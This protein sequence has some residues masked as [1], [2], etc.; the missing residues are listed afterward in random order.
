[1]KK[2]D[3]SPPIKAPT[4]A[5]S[6][7]PAKVLLTVGPEVFLARQ[8][9]AG[10]VKS[11]RATAPQIQV[12]ELA[13]K[14]PN[15]PM[16]V[17]EA[18]SPSLFASQSLVLITD[19][20]GKSHHGSDN[21]ASEAIDDASDVLV[22][23]IKG[24]PPEI[25]LGLDLAT[26]R[27]RKQLIEAAQLA[28]CQEVEC[29]KPSPRSIDTFIAKEFSK[30]RR[31]AAPEAI[32][33]L[34]QS[35][36]DDLPLLANAIEQICSDIT[37]ELISL[38]SV[39]IYHSGIAELPWYKVSEAVWSGSAVNVMNMVRE[40]FARDTTAALPMIAALAS[41]IRLM[42]RVAGL[43]RGM[44]EA[45]A[46]KQLGAH[47]YRV[48]VARQQL[49]RWG[50]TVLANAI[51]SLAELDS[52]VKGGLAGTGLDANARQHLVESAFVRIAAGRG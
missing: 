12:I 5:K 46:G 6:T 26:S 39:Q 31:Q 48:K 9:V 40:A 3:K 22:D 14:G 13:L 19:R 51:L 1:M 15:A 8:A 38:E 16:R 52:L 27:G 24:L 43:P 23:L 20:K 30:R 29:E 21:A 44:S 34:R 25:W 45:E 42:V 35:V 33:A 10:F 37:E 50:P 36:G 11:A 17:V 2:T 18:L 32:N 41:D 7:P 28:G 4:T 49:P 47:P